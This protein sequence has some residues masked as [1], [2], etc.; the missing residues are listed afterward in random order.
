MP[1]LP[2]IQEH[3]K[4]CYQFTL[5]RKCMS[6]EE[7]VRTL[8]TTARGPNRPQ[9]RQPQQVQGTP[10]QKMKIKGKDHQTRPVTT[11]CCLCTATHPFPFRN[12]FP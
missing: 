2:E 7:V 11:P 10:S 8:A 1:R 5:Q 9:T 12:Q 4:G 6:T 3:W